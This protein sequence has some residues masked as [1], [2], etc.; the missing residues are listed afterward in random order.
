VQEVLK[1]HAD[2]TITLRMP[3]GQFEGR[4]SMM[5]G[6]PDFHPGDEAVLFLTQQDTRG[7]PWVMGLSQGCFRIFRDPQSGTALVRY[8][9][10]DTELVDPTT[11]RV[12]QKPATP[13]PPELL[14]TFKQRLS[15]ILDHRPETPAGK[16]RP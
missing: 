10:S 15:R 7:F 13:P 9:V 2:A 12:L 11:G 14:E 3:G 8:A 5:H 6:V 16:D 1:G 4:R